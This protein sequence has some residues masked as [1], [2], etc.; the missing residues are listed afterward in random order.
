MVSVHDAE[1]AAHPPRFALRHDSTMPFWKS[2]PMNELQSDIP[3]ALNA[4]FDLAQRQKFD[5]K[6]RPA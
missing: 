5:E 4:R 6:A 3:D 2:I 1:L